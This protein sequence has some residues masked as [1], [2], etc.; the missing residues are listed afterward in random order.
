M[1]DAFGRT[2][3][4]YRGGDLAAARAEAEAALA[5]QPDSAA[6]LQLLGMILCQ[7]GDLIGGVQLLRRALALEP[8]D[9]PT[10]LALANA[11]LASGALDDAEEA[12]RPEAF[13]GSA[14]TAALRLRGYILQTAERFAEAAGCYEQ[15]LETAPDDW[16]IWN[17]LGNA[18][19]AAG[20]PPGS[21]LALARARG[22]RPDLPAIHF[23]L[24]LALAEAGRLEESAA[25]MREAL[26]LGAEEGPALLQLGKALRHMGR[27][28]EALEALDGAAA[29]T[30]AKA[31]VHVER[32]R[33]LAGL[34]RFD[35]AELAYQQALGA[36][37]DLAE[38]YVERG[39]LLERCNRLDRLAGLLGE[40]GSA[41]VA[42]D[43]LRHLHALALERAGRFDEALQEARA[44]P[45]GSEPARRA[46][47]IGRLADKAGDSA[48]AFEAYSQLNRLVAE[49][50][51]SARD[52]AA[53]YR[54]HVAALNDMLTPAYF[55]A[56][57]RAQ[58]DP[59]A[60]TA[61][62]FLVGF[63]RS[64]TTL[65]DT[66]LMGHPDTHVLEEEPLLQRVGEALGDF[67]RLPGLDAGDTH[68]LR[69]R[70]FAELD[71]LDPSARNKM[72]VDKLPLNILG[73]PLIHR[74]FPDSKLIF[75]QR[76]PCDVALSCFMQN[77]ELN[78]AM[79][80]FLD[81]S[82]TAR[83]YDLV[84][85]FW[86]K[87]REMLPLDVHVVRYEALVEDKE[88][89]LHRLIAFLGLPWD[90]RVLDHQGIAARRGAI[91]T[92]SYAQ[93]VQ[94]IYRRASG[95]WE[96]YR[97]QMEEVLPILAP[98]A[99]WLGYDALDLPQGKSGP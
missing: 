43:Q 49:D 68:R 64:G 21:V 17:N 58:P 4:L 41:A 61:P 51:P 46:L 94:P 50:Q 63:P 15:A 33:A 1:S 91:N 29:L 72:V 86:R 12:C 7:A 67:V 59:E 32:G 90:D 42:P 40:A 74:L 48:A 73:I 36:S 77:F 11:L 75:A 78:G 25:A 22:L 39:L 88:S 56:W 55:A 93:V 97:T 85:A 30:P 6:L 35:E 53:A 28:E 66:M 70:Y 69:A 19:R 14:P 98:W 9:A 10:R 92:P 45:A 84:L 81:L 76:H 31:E 20:D 89:E 5:G 62:V 79:A 16:E 52:D 2:V 99:D 80:N 26:R 24:G 57:K 96:R 18:R 8:G 54:R 47:L 34:Q 82:D 87:C 23:N 37:P 3:R 65:L 27:H 95:R 38:A 60:R 83:L 71:A 13:A 44:V